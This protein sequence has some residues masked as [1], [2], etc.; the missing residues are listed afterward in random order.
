MRG[1]GVDGSV[2]RKWRKEHGVT[3][4]LLAARLPCDSKTIRHAEQSKRL[5]A[6]TVR[7]IADA[8]GVPLGAIVVQDDDPQRIAERNAQLSH[9]WQSV[10]NTRDVAALMDFYHDDA[11]LLVPGAED[12]PAGG[13]FRGKDA[14]GEHF[15]GAFD[16]FRTEVLTPDRYKLDAVGEY[17]FLRVRATAEVLATGQSFT[18]MVVHELEIK[19]G[20]IHRHTMV[21]DTAAIR[22]CM[23]RTTLPG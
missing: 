9:D 16:T 3:Q 5:D 4:E 19:D 11:T 12:L 15:R 13:E 6:S 22:V 2:L 18:A 1:I 17:V 10:Y 8:M 7:R 21:C 23:P 14:I 20:K